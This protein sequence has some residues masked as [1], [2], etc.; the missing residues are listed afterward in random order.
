MGTSIGRCRTRDEVQQ[1]EDQ[2]CFPYRPAF[3]TIVNA[4]FG[5]IVYTLDSPPADA[6]TF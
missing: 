1:G 2:A 6:V 3:P 5:A 4:R